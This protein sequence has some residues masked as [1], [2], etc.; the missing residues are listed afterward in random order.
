[1]DQAN[2]FAVAGDADRTENFLGHDFREA[3]NRVQ[4]RAQ[5]MAH[6]GEEGRLGPV[7]L[8]GQIACIDEVTFMGL[9]IGNITCDSD[10]IDTFTVRPRRRPAAYF[11]PQIGAIRTSLAH[12]GRRGSTEIA[13]FNKGGL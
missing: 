10:N 4:R 5:L 11:C 6:I 9:A 7:G 1:M 12:L 8:L 13:G 3:D 2:I